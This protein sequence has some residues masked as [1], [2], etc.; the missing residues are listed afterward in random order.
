MRFIT[1]FLLVGVLLAPAARA[2]QGGL[3]DGVDGIVTRPS[4]YGVVDAMARIE[5]FALSSGAKVIARVDM[6]DLAHKAG[7]KIPP[8][9][10]LIFDPG[11]LVG[12]LV[13]QAP[14]AALDLPFKVLVWED[15]A[16]HAWIS[17][18]NATALT[19]RFAVDPASAGVRDANSEL[20]SILTT[21][22]K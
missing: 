2:Q 7:V 6:A 21:A 16:G 5:A 4:R 9:Q 14:M 12:P 8:N 20:E 19:R 13:Q 1:L 3:L 17:Y 18:A 22:M 15:A 11:K 10:L